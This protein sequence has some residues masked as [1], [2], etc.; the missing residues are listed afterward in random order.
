MANGASIEVKGLQTTLR[1]LKI[2]D[3][4]AMKAMRKGF[5]EAA[6]PI[7]DKAKDRVPEP[8]ALSNWGRWGGRLDWDSSK[9]KRGLKSQISVT[10]RYAAFRLVS[11]NAA[12]AIYENAGSQSPNSRL[13]Q[14]LDNS[15]RGP[16]PR[17]LVRTWK[18]EKGIRLLHTKVGRLIQ[19][20][21]DRVQRAII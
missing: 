3:P 5:R 6:K 16:A 8:S 4:E 1:A 7:I 9:V 21:Q 20:A 12:G 15:G 19:D 10:K 14:G 2:I 17:L 18:E 13:V 11:S